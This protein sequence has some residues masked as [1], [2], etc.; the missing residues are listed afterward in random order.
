MGR[1]NVKSKQDLSGIATLTYN[2]IAVDNIRRENLKVHDG[3][4]TVAY[5]RHPVYDAIET[6]E[7]E[8]LR[9]FRE[10]MAIEIPDT[11]KNPK[12]LHFPE[13]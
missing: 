12:L 4:I 9:I 7:A 1:Y 2:P 10:S 8:K 11:C 6:L 5:S 13:W 3:E